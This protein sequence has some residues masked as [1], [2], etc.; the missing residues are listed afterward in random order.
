MFT[1][2][3]K[4]EK[5]FDFNRICEL[6]PELKTESFYAIKSA[7][8]W[9]DEK[10]MVRKDNSLYWDHI[11][12]ADNEC[13]INKLTKV[14]MEGS[15]LDIDL[16]TGELVALPNLEFDNQYCMNMYFGESN[17]NVNMYYYS[18]CYSE[19]DEPAYIQIK[20]DYESDV[21]F[22]EYPVEY[23]KDTS[24]RIGKIDSI[25]REII[26]SSRF[27]AGYEFEFLTILKEDTTVTTNT[28]ILYGFL[29]FT[30]KMGEPVNIEVFA[31]Y[32]LN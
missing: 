26:L 27:N 12:P 8:K 16:E 7:L 14:D 5:K 21:K 32:N 10:N 17:F 20:L 22:R 15:A 3:Y 11:N 9:T 29:S 13:D 19:I 24:F 2:E 18:N 1:T 25:S 28:P 23:E 4:R 6:A 30:D 31:S